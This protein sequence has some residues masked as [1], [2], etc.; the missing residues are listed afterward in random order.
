LLDRGE[1]GGDVAEVG[2][3]FVEDGFEER[4]AGVA[5][6]PA[7]F[8]CADQQACEL[9]GCVE[10]AAEVVVFACFAAEEGV[11]VAELD[12]FEGFAVG[13]GEFG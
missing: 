6:W 5:Q 11:E 2:G 13:G 12:A 1:L 9:F 10:A 8:G 7:A 3:V 4:F